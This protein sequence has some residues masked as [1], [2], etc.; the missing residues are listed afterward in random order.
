MKIQELFTQFFFY[1]LRH[2]E[3]FNKLLSTLRTLSCGAK[4]QRGKHYMRTICDMSN[5][6]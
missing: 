1:F 3:T 6:G 5:E 4:E 2:L